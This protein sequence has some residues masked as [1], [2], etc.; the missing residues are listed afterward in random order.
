MA[1]RLIR[2]VVLKLFFTLFTSG[3]QIFPCSPINTA[4]FSFVAYE[5]ISTYGGAQTY[6]NLIYLFTDD[7]S[8]YLSTTS[9]SDLLPLHISQHSDSTSSSFSSSLRNESTN[10]IS[11]KKENRG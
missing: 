2:N 7:I 1:K 9:F 11:N 10:Q 4:I 6:M 5:I 3:V 8:S